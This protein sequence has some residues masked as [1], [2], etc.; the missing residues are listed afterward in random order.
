MGGEHAGNGDGRGV[1]VAL[2]FG[3]PT[4]RNRRNRD[5]ADRQ[6]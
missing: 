5:N 4:H 2:V 6:A 3:S 1:A